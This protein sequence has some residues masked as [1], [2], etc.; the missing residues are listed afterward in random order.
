MIKARLR[1][2]MIRTAAQVP[3]AQRMFLE[4]ELAKLA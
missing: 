3:E 4:Y 2:V 1:T